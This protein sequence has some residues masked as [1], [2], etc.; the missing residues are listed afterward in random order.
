MTIQIEAAYATEFSSH[1]VLERASDTIAYDLQGRND[2]PHR[3]MEVS[4]EMI[5]R[6][7]RSGIKVMVITKP[8]GRNM[9]DENGIVYHEEYLV[10]DFVTPQTKVSV[11]TVALMREMME[12]LEKASKALLG[13]AK[14]DDGTAKLYY[15]KTTLE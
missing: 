1:K 11:D 5:N 14:N 7:L 8:T 15:F 13:Y 9:T 6:T 3:D 10:V 4:H 2:N 12:V